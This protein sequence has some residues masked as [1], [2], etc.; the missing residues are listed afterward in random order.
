[1]E[2]DR[3]KQDEA[4]LRYRIAIE[5]QLEHSAEVGR[6]GRIEDAGARECEYERLRERGKQLDEDEDVYRA[7]YEKLNCEE[8]THRSA[9][10]FKTGVIRDYEKER[11]DS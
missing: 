9:E 3:P 6:C 1:M 7:E 8:V 11:K 5:R 10:E 4:I 2:A